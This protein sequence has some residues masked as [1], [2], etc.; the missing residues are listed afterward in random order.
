MSDGIKSGKL[1]PVLS[2]GLASG[3]VI[4]TPG[5]IIKKNS[6]IPSRYVFCQ[7]PSQYRTLQYG[8]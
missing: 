3:L 6:L 1:Y 4:V 5:S 8:P 7:I 2:C